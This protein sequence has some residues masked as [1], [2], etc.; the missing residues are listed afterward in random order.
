M[1]ILRKR[2]QRFSQYANAS[3]D[4]VIDSTKLLTKYEVT[5][6]RT[7]IFKFDEKQQF[8]FLPLP[9]E[10]QRTCIRAI[11]TKSSPLGAHDIVLAGNYRTI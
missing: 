6:L 5:E 4:E 3:I 9:A 1:P 2:F 7:G 8:S 11:T 10:A